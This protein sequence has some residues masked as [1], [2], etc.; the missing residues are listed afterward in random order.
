V[1]PGAGV[2]SA[3]KSSSLIDQKVSVTGRLGT[4]TRAE[5][6]LHVQQGGGTFVEDFSPRVALLIVG[7]DGWPLLETGKLT[8]ALELAEL[9]RRQG[10]PVRI[11]SEQT[12]RELVGLDPTPAAS[13]GSYTVEQVAGILNVEASVLERWEQFGLVRPAAGLYDFRDLV[14]LR[15][16][17]DLVVRGVSPRVIR[18][19]LEG[20]QGLLPGVEQPLAQLKILADGGR[21]L[22]EVGDVLLSPDGQFELD[23]E[24]R[25]AAPPSGPAHTLTAAPAE[26]AEW[27][28]RGVAHEAA[29]R[30]KDAER[31]YR[32]AI[33]IAPS[34]AAA[35]FNLGTVLLARKRPQAAAERLA[36]ATAL[37]PT[38]AVAWFNLAHAQE[39]LG[40]LRS[41]ASSLRRAIAADPDYTDG[42]YNLAQLREK[43]GDSKGA[44]RSWQEYLKRDPS[45]AWADEARRRLAATRG[46][47]WA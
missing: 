6:A 8:R 10:L 37:D 11:I 28:A 4:M 44:A 19:S 43:L 16:V 47:S 5:I 45:S 13:G 15:T 31:A 18:K 27:I 23:F 33:R 3:E 21:L 36:Q 35:Q 20:L 30:L 32:R 24:R 40:R 1:N 34:D 46:P 12:F 25:D 22:A 29:G 7:M 42:Y 2:R 17:A 14:S 9:A 39:E 26:A 38:M 41:A